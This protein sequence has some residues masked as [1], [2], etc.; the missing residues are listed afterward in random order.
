MFKGPEALCSEEGTG[1][2]FSQ[3]MS[4]IISLD[5]GRKETFE[6]M[7]QISLFKMPPLHYFLVYC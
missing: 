6:Y 2:V 4:D 7:S 1:M 3:Y 5:P